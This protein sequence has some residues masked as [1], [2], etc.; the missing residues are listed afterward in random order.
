[1][2]DLSGRTKPKS[3]EKR[4]V[5]VIQMTINVAIMMITDGFECKKM[6]R[7]LNDFSKFIL[8]NYNVDEIRTS[9]FEVFGQ[10]TMKAVEE[11]HPYQYKVLSEVFGMTIMSD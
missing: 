5:K 3:G 11:V 1:M 6:R 7:Y 8:S 2:T 9:I 4:K 10:K